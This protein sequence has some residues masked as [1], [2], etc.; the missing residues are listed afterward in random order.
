MTVS[1]DDN[2]LS[3]ASYNSKINLSEG[4][5]IDSSTNNSNEAISES[6]ANDESSEHR[7]VI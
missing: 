1:I 3:L 5:P 2:R 6:Y 7:D 4:I